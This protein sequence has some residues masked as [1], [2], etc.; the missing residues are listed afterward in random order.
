MGEVRDPGLDMLI[1]L[2]KEFNE[3]DKLVAAICAAPGV[4]AKADLLRGLKATCFP[5]GELI[6]L[7]KEHGANYVNKRVVRDRNI[8]T[9]VGPE[10]AKDFA[11]AICEYLSGE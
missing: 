9:S 11:T 5:N 7:L 2:C 10:T 4:L 3:R 6:K 8:I 1:K